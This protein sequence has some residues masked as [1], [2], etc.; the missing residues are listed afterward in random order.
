M[1]SS[2]KS[3]AANA[4]KKAGAEGELT[5]SQKDLGEDEKVLAELHSDCMEKASDFEAETTS[6]G[7]EL[8]ALATAKKLIK[9]AT[10]LAQVSS[11]LQ[12][13]QQTSSL[14]AVKIVRNLAFA[15]R[16]SSLAR[17]AAKMETV[18]KANA[19]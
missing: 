18:A 2:K 4:E 12:T 6:R 11:F 19:N 7:E 3:I 5:T 16:S 13:A 14:N 10:S 8:K 9:E 1:D 17:F 15:Q